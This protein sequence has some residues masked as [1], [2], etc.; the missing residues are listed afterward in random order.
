MNVLLNVESIAPP[1]TGIGR[2]TKEILS[3]LMKLGSIDK[4]WCFDTLKLVDS[5]EV[6][7]FE[8]SDSPKKFK[9]NKSK[10][11][12]YVRSLPGAYNT[13][14]KIREC[15]FRLRTKHFK[16][17]VYHEPNYI[18]KPYAGPKVMTLHDLS[19]IHYPEFH[20]KERVSNLEKNLNSSLNK[21]DKII[22]VSHY[23]KNEIVK[24]LAVPESRIEAIHLGVNPEYAPREK[25]EAASV[26]SRYKIKY[27]SYLLVVATFE[28]RKNLDRLLVAYSNLSAKLRKMYP[29][30]LAGASGW[31]EAV[32]GKRIAALES[33]GELQR[34]GY[35]NEGDLPYIYAGAAAFAFPSVY[36]GFGLPPL[37]AMACGVPVVA[38]NTSSM[39]EVLG[40]AAQYINPYDIDD[41]QDSLEEVLGSSGKREQM[42]NEGIK[43]AQQFTWD[44]CVQKTASLYNEV[45]S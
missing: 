7:N 18:L 37:E 31:G 5:K 14:S 11:K 12:G 39:P 16:N 19:H 15:M 20:P 10:L 25:D 21:A 17:T 23:I 3:G 2:Y 43:R 34:I 41:I 30:V 6:G 44:R 24:Y 35:V 13:H 33:R 27:G 32:N 40:T 42:A 29:L 9:N 38:S 45:N 4:V 1:L 8:N 26:L 28:P 36:E 22:T